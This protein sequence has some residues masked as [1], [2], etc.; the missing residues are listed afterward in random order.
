[1]QRELDRL[2]GHVAVSVLERDAKPLARA[3]AGSRLEVLRHALDDGD[4]DDLFTRGNVRIL[5]ADADARENAELAEALLGEAHQAAAVESADLERDAAADQAFVRR[6]R[7]AH[8]DASDANAIA[9][10]R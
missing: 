10:A 8:V 2:A 3:E 5:E 1:M 4:D 6:A 7:A 9:L